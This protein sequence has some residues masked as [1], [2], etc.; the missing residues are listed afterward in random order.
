MSGKRNILFFTEKMIH[1]TL[2]FTRHELV[3]LFLTVMHAIPWRIKAI[4]GL[5]FL[6]PVRPGARRT[7]NECIDHQG[8][9]PFPSIISLIVLS[10]SDA[11]FFHEVSY[12]MTLF[13]H[14]LSFLPNSLRY[15]H[16]FAQTAT[17]FLE[18][19]K[20]PTY[21]PSSTVR[22]DSVNLQAIL[23]LRSCRRDVPVL[24]FSVQKLLMN[25]KP[26]LNRLSKQ[27]QS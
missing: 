21:I 2:A 17:L 6:C 18:M 26:R 23:V 22:M 3:S 16:G 11:H 14:V 4:M 5:N 25:R 24:S 10:V 20:C 13:T 19:L 27:S 12:Q 9:C 8:S 7:N 15:S 1:D